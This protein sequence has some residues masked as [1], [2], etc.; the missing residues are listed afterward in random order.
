MASVT[1]LRRAD[2]KTHQ[3]TVDEANDAVALGSIERTS[4]GTGSL[5]ADALVTSITIGGGASQT[6]TTIGKS[7]QVTNILGPLCTDEGIEGPDDGTGIIIGLTPTGA[8]TGS[9]FQAI[10]LTT[11]ERDQLVAANGMLV[12]N[13]TTGSIEGYNGSWLDLGAGAGGASSLASTLAVGN[14]TGGNDLEVSTGDDIVGAAELDLIAGA[15]TNAITIRGGAGTT[16][17]GA[18][19]AFGGTGGTGVGGQVWLQGGTGGTGDQAGGEVLLRGGTG[20]NTDGAGGDVTIGGGAAT[21]IGAD[22]NVVIADANTTAVQIAAGSSTS[23]V[24]IGNASA[25]AVSLNSGAASDWNVTS[26]NLTLRTLTS[27]SLLLVAAGSCNIDSSGS[28]ALNSQSGILTGTDADNQPIQIGTAGVRGVTLGSTTSTSSTTIQTGTGALTLTAGGALD[29]NAAGAVTIDSSGAGVSID[30]VTSSNVTVTGSGQDLTLAAAGGGAQQ[31]I[32][33]SAGTGLDA[34]RLN[35][36]AG[37]FDI[38][39]V[40]ISNIAVTGAAQNLLLSVAGGGIQTLS[41]TSAG[42]GNQAID[43]SATAGGVDIDGSTTSSFNVLSNSASN[44]DLQIQVQNSG[45]GSGR[46]DIDADVVLIDA[47]AGISV[48]VA[49]ASNITVSGATADLTLGARGATITLNESGNT[50][51]SGF[52]A[53]SIVGALNEALAAGGGTVVQ[54]VNA[55][56][57]TVVTINASIPEDDTIPQDTEG[58]A[59]IT[60]QITPT[61]TANELHVSFHC[62]ASVNGNNSL[63]AALFQDQDATTTNAIGATI[64]GARNQADLTPQDLSLVKVYTPGT[65]N[66]YTFEVRVGC[67]STAYV[68]GDSAGTRLFGGIMEATLVIEEKTP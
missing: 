40:A 54:T 62:S 11:T 36:S 28:L 15:G 31:L 48:D 47:A 63:T 55:S 2:G 17:G 12:Y 66:T 10:S 51:L 56:V 32:L 57:A 53:T 64:Q 3:Q 46:L 58:V 38:D 1:L 39:A 30:G 21:G 45:A 23:S 61:S 19:R 43:I 13:E 26:A 20:G 42:T 65:T 27:G 67:A 59:V 14:T 34:I 50:S 44:Q 6:T 25:G 29:A 52:T 35:A 37:G 33:N 22:G 24:T 68:N 60:A 18:A 5:W 8:S 41:L 16:T 49:T 4:A 9:T 7:G